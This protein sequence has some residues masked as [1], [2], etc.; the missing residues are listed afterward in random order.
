M[1]TFNFN[2]PQC[3]N[4]LSAEDEWRG[5]ETQ[6]PTCNKNI[7][8]PPNSSLADNIKKTYDTDIEKHLNLAQL[9]LKNAAFSEAHKEF[10]IVLKHNPEDI[11]ALYGEIL[12]NAYISASQNAKLSDAI[13]AYQK[14]EYLL[15]Q[16]N[17]PQHTLIDFRRKFIADFSVLVSREYCRVFSALNES[18][19]AASDRAVLNLVNA[20]H[21]GILLGNQEAIY[22]QE[23]CAKLFPYMEEIITVRFFIISLI[24]VDELINYPDIMKHCKILFEST[25]NFHTENDEIKNKYNLLLKAIHNSEIAE[26]MNSKNISREKAEEFVKITTELQNNGSF[27]P[28]IRT[29]NICFALL[30]IPSIIIFLGNIFLLTVMCRTG[31]NIP[32]TIVVILSIGIALAIAIS[33]GALAIRK[34]ANALAER[35]NIA[36]GYGIDSKN[37]RKK[38]TPDA[39]DLIL[40]MAMFTIFSLGFAILYKPHIG[41]FI[42]GAIATF[43]VYFF[44]KF[45]RFFSNFY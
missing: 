40:I 15:N 8:I 43:G 42:L 4:L 35:M 29:L 41:A 7:T 18:K 3:G 31:K 27:E 2:C 11:T 20:T 26:I 9:A 45:V 25:V 21:K 39:K 32:P 28:R 12:S 13:Y 10:S 23:Q 6:C 1:A 44:Y 17:Q 36:K 24:N 22:H 14:A 34:K 37:Y 30:L 33:L 38:L 16:N 5:M 19:T